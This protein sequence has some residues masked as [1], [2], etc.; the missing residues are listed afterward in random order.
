MSEAR[1]TKK[2]LCKAIIFKIVVD[3]DPIISFN[4]AAV[5]LNKVLMRYIGDHSDLSQELSY[6]LC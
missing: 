6:S 5:Q 3:K 4:T 2:S 1:I